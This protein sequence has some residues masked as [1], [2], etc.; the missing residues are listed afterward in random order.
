LVLHAGS[1][2][3]RTP[4][5]A[6]RNSSTLSVLAA[7]CLVAGM[8]VLRSAVLCCDPLCCVVLCSAPL[9]CARSNWHGAT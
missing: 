3:C 9:C 7:G 5:T 8:R 4:S 2:S 1:A 6:C